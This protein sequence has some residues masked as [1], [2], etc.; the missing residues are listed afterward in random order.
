MILYGNESWV[1]MGEFAKGPGG[2]HHWAARQIT[3]MKATH[4]GAES[5]D[6]PSGDVNGSRK[7]PPHE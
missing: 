4:G 5:G 7:A 6:N 1:V 3:G 2:F